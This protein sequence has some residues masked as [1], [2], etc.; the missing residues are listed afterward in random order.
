MGQHTYIMKLFLLCVLSNV[1]SLFLWKN[2]NP[3]A[4]NFFQALPE[5]ERDYLRLLTTQMDSLPIFN[6]KRDFF[7]SFGDIETDL[8]KLL[9]EKL[10]L[11]QNLNLMKYAEI[12]IIKY[13]EP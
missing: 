2:T 1:Y 12:M 8:K 5:A 10:N 11:L 4:D 7:G 6:Q 3:Q 9:K 13:S